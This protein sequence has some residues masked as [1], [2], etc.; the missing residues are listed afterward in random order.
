MID[1]Q[2][3]TLGHNLYYGKISN[4][5]DLKN[6]ILMHAKCF[7]ENNRPNLSDFFNFFPLGNSQF[8]T[9]CSGE[10]PKLIN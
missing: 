8:F 1:L 4:L 9:R 10:K 7:F 3:N 5:L 2:R 6:M